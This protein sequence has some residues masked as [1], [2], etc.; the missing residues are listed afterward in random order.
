[1]LRRGQRKGT[2]T[3]DKLFLDKPPADAVALVQQLAIWLPADGRLLWQLGELAHSH[4]DMRTAAAILDGCVSEFGMGDPE[5]RH[6]RSAYRAAADEAAKATMPSD[7]Q[8]HV[9]V[10][11]RSPRPLARRSDLSRLPPIHA[12]GLNTLPWAVFTATT[13]DRDQRPK[14]HPH[15]R[16]LDGKKVALTGFL[17]PVGDDPN[18]GAFLLIEYPVGCW[19]CE[20]PEPTGVVLVELP[21][22]KSATFT[23]NQVKVTGRLALNAA[24][25]ESFMFTVRDAA[26]VP[27][28]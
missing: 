18:T 25:P 5:L 2:Q 8:Q 17:Q 7:H 10:G 6:H 19:F 27:P 14:F 1:M 16:A 12:D 23:K 20:M 21:E 3:F 28:D 9:S 24:D 26:I 15:L 13:R 4:G 11:F 22:G